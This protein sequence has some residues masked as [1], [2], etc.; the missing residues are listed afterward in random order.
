MTSL[1]RK[2]TWWRQ[3]RRKEDELREELAFHLDEEAGERQAVGLSEEDARWAARRDLG[4]VTLLLEETRTLWSWTLLEQL[5]QDVRYG[6][7]TLAANK[8]FTAMA[9]LSLALGIG[10]NTAIF[11]FMDSIFLRSLPVP[12]PQSL[13]ILSWRT[14]FREIHGSN[15]H[16]NSF[17]D[18]NGGFVGGFFSYPAFEWLRNERL[19]LLGRLW[20]SRRR[21]PQ[22]HGRGPGRARTYGIRVGRLFPRARDFARRRTADRPGRR[23]RQRAGHGCRQLRPEPEALWRRRECAGTIDSDQQP[24]VHGD[25]RRPARILRRRSRQPA[26]RLSSRCTPTCFSRTGTTRPPHTSTRTTTGSCRW[27]ACVP[28]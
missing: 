4:N 10:A 14:P 17:A 23:S 18:P 16:D 13:V 25:R 24:P 21:R 11:S 1:F 15:R 12:E 22:P 19:G 5:V 28:A 9:I 26:G 20:V 3:R 8:T 27:R 6:L 7:R 2:F